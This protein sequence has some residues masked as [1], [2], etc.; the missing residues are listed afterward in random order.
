MGQLPPIRDLRQYPPAPDILR[1][2]ACSPSAGS[3]IHCLP[4]ISRP[5]AVVAHRVDDGARWLLDVLALPGVST[6]VR[7]L[8]DG[9]AAA[10]AVIAAQLGRVQDDVK[11]AIAL[12]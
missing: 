1:V 4:R 2:G 10:R 7:E 5:S 3:E 11:V 12:S 6:E 8:R 9:A